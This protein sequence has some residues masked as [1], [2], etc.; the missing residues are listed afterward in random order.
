MHRYYF[1][2]LS[3]GVLHPDEFGIEMLDEDIADQAQAALMDIMRELIPNKVSMVVIV[4]VRPEHGQPVYVAH[5]I[6]GGHS[7]KEA[8]AYSI[9]NPGMN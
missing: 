9:E 7:V 5:G 2:C 8:P 3:D 4:T 1:D 6:V